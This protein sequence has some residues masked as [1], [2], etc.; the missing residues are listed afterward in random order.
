MFSIT[1]NYTG[2]MLLYSHSIINNISLLKKAR[3]IILRN[4]VKRTI[5]RS[6]EGAQLFFSIN[7]N[8][9]VGCIK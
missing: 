2:S 7:Y 5:K 4:G 6:D 3:K 8:F 1:E 9:I